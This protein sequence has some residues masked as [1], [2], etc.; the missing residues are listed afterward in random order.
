MQNDKL[1]YHTILCLQRNGPTHK[2]QESLNSGGSDMKRK[3]TTSSTD[4]AVVSD[5]KFQN[6][7]GKLQKLRKQELRP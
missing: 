6:M 7:F 4:Q 3:T 1:L 5:A 2:W